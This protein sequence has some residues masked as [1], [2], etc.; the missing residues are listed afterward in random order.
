MARLQVQ[1]DLKDA[2]GSKASR[3]KLVRLNKAEAAE[4]RSRAGAGLDAE[5]AKRS[6]NAQPSLKECALW[7]ISGVVNRIPVEEC[8]ICGKRVMPPASESSGSTGELHIDRVLCGHWFHTKCLDKFMTEPPF[9]KACP[10]CSQPVTHP[11]YP[12]MKIPE[13]RWAMEQAR[14]REVGEVCE[15]LGVDEA[16]RVE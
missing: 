11:R 10:S 4:E 1:S 9:G 15:F 8:Q 13:Q 7:W 16:N 3:R 6:S 14:E 2:S 12:S 5:Q